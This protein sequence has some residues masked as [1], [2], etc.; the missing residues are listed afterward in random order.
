[1]ENIRRNLYFLAQYKLNVHIRQ[2]SKLLN[3]KHNSA[4]LLVPVWRGEGGDGV[5][6]GGVIK[7][8]VLTKSE[9]GGP[10]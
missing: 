2:T 3:R 8:V 10:V 7:R 4:V 6:G 9:V 1:M 5:D